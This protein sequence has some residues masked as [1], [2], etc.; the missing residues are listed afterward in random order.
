MKTVNIQNG[1]MKIH[2]KYGIT[3]MANYKIQLLFEEFASQQ[4]LSRDEL[5][6]AYRELVADIDKHSET[7]IVEVQLRQRISELELTNK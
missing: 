1:V 5:I 4:R 2:H 7:T 6:E 3:E